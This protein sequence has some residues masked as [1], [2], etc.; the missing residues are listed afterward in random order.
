VNLDWLKSISARVGV[1]GRN[2]IIVAGLGFCAFALWLFLKEIDRHPWIALGFLTASFVLAA[3]V[4]LVGLLKPPLPS[5]VAEKFLLQQIGHQTIY[6]GG[7]QSGSELAQLLR[8]FHNVRELPAPAAIVAGDAGNA[9]NYQ[10]LQPV[11]ANELLDKDRDG[12]TKNLE[13]EAQRIKSALGTKRTGKLPKS[14]QLARGAE[15]PKAGAAKMKQIT[16]S[17]STDERKT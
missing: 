7:L 3:T 15:E 2:M 10:D 6:A 8:V 16:L 17:E 14:V 9:E 5:E 4:I 12:V 11:E 13:E 1:E